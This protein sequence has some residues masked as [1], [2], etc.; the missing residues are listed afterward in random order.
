MAIWKSEN[1]LLTQKG[2]E[3][4]NKVKAGVG[5]ITVTRVVAGSG[6]VPPSQ[7]Y[8]Q[9]A[10]SGTTKPMTI[11]QV[12]T[13]E[14]GS[15][16]SINI[17][18]DGFTE[19]FN[20]NQIGVY[21]SHE[22][23]DGEVLYHI[24][25]CE[26]DG[27]DVV[28]P[29]SNTPANFG[30]NLFLEHSNESSISITVNP[31][32]SVSI[33]DFEEYKVSI[34]SRIANLTYKDVGALSVSGGDMTGPINMNDHPISGLSDPTEDT[35]AARKRYVDV[36]KAAANAYTDTAKSE[37]NAYTDTAKAEA[38]SYTDTAKA[39][40]N[41]YTDTAKEEAKSYTDSKRLTKTATITTTWSGSGPYT[42]AVSVSGILATDMPH[43]MPV[44][45]TTNAT[46]IAQKEAWACVSKAETSANTI[47]FTCFEEA[48]TTAVQIQIEVMR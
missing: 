11:A 3:I 30:Y 45:S 32:G 44:Y 15:E 41:A 16:I 5:S 2:V 14:E 17:T 10:I 23:Y 27:V 25:Q 21:V 8:T 26:A 6:R 13:R 43:I 31:Q 46:A 38:K 9:I 36:A 18:N 29:I 22:D 37:A 35:Q 4:L 1:S 39:E 19:S 34:E 42:Q 24:S 33:P 47:T 12:R 40:A 20:I 28:P 48:P 7:L